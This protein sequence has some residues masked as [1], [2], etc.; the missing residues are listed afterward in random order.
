MYILETIKALL[1]VFV[2]LGVTMPFS[3]SK[4][5]YLPYLLVVMFASIFMV[6]QID[7]VLSLL[8]CASA[9]VIVS[10][11]KSKSPN[12]VAPKVKAKFVVEPKSEFNK[13]NK[14]DKKTIQDTIPVQ[15]KPEAPLPKEPVECSLIKK[16]DPIA[17]HFEKIKDKMQIIQTNVFDDLNQK[18]FYSEL[19][20]HYNIQGIEQDAVSGYDQYDH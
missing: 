10:S 17:S 9:I 5:P 8:L 20:E 14:T 13:L 16:P 1:G 11:I 19:G 6:Y 7:F 12:K 2:V 3:I 18:V 15:K 4:H